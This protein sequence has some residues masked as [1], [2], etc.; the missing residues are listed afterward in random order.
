MVAV[1]AVRAHV[2][3]TRFAV[4][5]GPGRSRRI[6]FFRG[7]AALKRK[8]GTAGGR[9]AKIKATNSNKKEL[10]SSSSSSTHFASTKPIHHTQI[11][12]TLWP[13]VCV[14][15]SCLA[16]RKH[17]LTHSTTAPPVGWWPISVVKSAIQHKQALTH[18]QDTDTLGF[19]G[20]TVE[21]KYGEK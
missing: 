8:N 19:A 3:I 14:C 5:I 7:E 20:K 16:H 15:R 6:S 21:R 4:E 18:T 1:V 17:T 2:F 12:S 9:S 10:A 13:A 11:H